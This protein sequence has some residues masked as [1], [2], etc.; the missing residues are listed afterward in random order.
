MAEE[1]AKK[2]AKYLHQEFCQ[3]NHTDGCSYHYMKSWDGFAK[4]EWLDKA[5]FILEERYL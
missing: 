4:K 3:S 1:K 5:K 2:L